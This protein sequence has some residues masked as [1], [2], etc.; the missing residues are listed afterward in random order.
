[1]KSG[2]NDD[3]RSAKRNIAEHE[4]TKHSVRLPNP[5]G[6]LLLRELNHR[7]DNEL[8]C[9]ICMISANAI[10]TDNVA[11]KAALLD[12]VDLL[13]QCADVHRALRMPTVVTELDTYAFATIC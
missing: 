13:H 7:I 6:S 5:D 9:A 1:L 8:T 11:V 3:Q 10:E 4:M 2:E 12:V